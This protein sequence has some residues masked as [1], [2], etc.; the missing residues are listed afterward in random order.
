MD[1]KNILIFRI[2][3]LGDTIVA[4]PALWS[5][6]ERFP[7]S[8][9][10]L[11]TN[12]DLR[13]RHYISPASVLPQNGLI[14]EFIAYPTNLRSVFKAAALLKLIGELRSR[15][16]DLAIYLMPR[17]RT[18][19]QVTRDTIFFRLCG[20]RGLIGSDFLLRNRL[21][22]PCPKPLSSTIREARFLLEMLK[23]LGIEPGLEKTDLLLTPVEL[24]SADRWIR[25]SSAAAGSATLIAIAPGAKW[26]S[27][28]WA[29]ENYSEIVSMLLQDHD[30]FPVIFGG[31]EDREAG[32]RMLGR[33]GRG[34]NA[35]GILTVRESAALLRECALY[36][37]NDTGTMHLASAVG[38]P[39]VAIFAAVDWIGR[40]DPFGQGNRLFRSA[41]HCEGCEPGGCVNKNR[42]LELIPKEEVY[43][44]CVRQINCE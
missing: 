11:L 10:T 22:V 16:F 2:G 41:F 36:L 19:L 15:Q 33:W 24:A 31:K 29:E 4:L 43:R 34:A 13:N 37:G 7:T 5:L 27:K 3:H 9:L 18:P 44:E 42:C 38:T 12:I 25:E 23:D 6:R 1:P 28:R 32:D 26:K 14:D 30:V 40:W 39:C 20:L 21:E 35:A 8:R 17:Q